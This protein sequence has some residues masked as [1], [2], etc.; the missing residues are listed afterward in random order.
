MIGGSTFWMSFAFI[1]SARGL[2]H[3]GSQDRGHDLA[4]VML[5]FAMRR[6]AAHIGLHSRISGGR[7]SKVAAALSRGPAASALV[8]FFKDKIVGYPLAN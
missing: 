4:R 1:I 7:H 3:A 5:R 6:I 8:P 2:P